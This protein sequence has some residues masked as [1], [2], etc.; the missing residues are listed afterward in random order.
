MKEDAHSSEMAL[1]FQVLFSH[2]PDCTMS[3]VVVINPLLQNLDFVTAFLS[4]TNK[5]VVVWRQ[6]VEGMSC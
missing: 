3:A 1:Y 4:H 2:G 6:G 5:E